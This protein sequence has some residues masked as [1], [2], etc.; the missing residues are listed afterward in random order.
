LIVNF[1]AGCWNFTKKRP[2]AGKETG[3]LRRE[4]K[5]GFQRAGRA[6]ARPGGKAGIAPRWSA[7]RRTKSTENEIITTIM[8]ECDG[9]NIHGQND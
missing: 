7:V 4:D 5:A 2:G 1:E 3:E 8:H 9:F 6:E